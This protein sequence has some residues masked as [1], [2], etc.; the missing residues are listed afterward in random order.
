MGRVVHP[1]TGFAMDV[2]DVDQ[3][4]EEGWQ[5]LDNAPPAEGE[6]PKAKSKPKPRTSRAT[7]KK[8]AAA[9]A[10]AP[11]SDDDSDEG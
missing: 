3:Y 10:D 1:V 2:D 11:K 6:K 8:A 7:A 4:V 9:P 5:E